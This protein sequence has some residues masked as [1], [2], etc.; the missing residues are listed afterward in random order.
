MSTEH[1]KHT[2]E[3]L[4]GF[5]GPMAPLRESINSAVR[6]YLQ[7]MPDDPAHPMSVWR[8]TEWTITSWGVV[9][10]NRGHERAHI[11]PKGWLSGVLYVQLPEI[12]NDPLR[13]P[14]G[15]L[16]FGRP[17]SQLHVRTPPEVIHYQPRYGVMYLFPSYFYHGTVPFRSE[18]R[19]ICV[20]F[21][22]EP[23]G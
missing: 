17:T 4:A 16:E 11:H 5:D 3:L 7:N 22:I 9:M 10:F 19:R 21:D 15:W 20:A 14:E 13:R 18:E 23:A 2:G 8:P 1:G 6:A 12:I